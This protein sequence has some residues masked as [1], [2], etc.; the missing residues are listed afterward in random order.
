MLQAALAHGVEL[1]SSCR[2]GTWRSCL[3][4]LVQGEVKY[5]IEWPGVTREEQDAGDFL[6][7][8]AY[9]QGDIVVRIP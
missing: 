4:Q 8:V 9:A 3:C 7:C 6:P 2:N 5:H 1:P